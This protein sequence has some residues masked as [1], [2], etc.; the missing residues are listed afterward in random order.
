MMLKKS[1]NNVYKLSAMPYGIALLFFFLSHIVA[2]L[3]CKFTLQRPVFF[4][5]SFFSVLSLV[6]GVL[7]DLHMFYFARASQ[8]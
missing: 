2:I 8:F 3:N 1:L 7:L 5:I 4:W 6:I